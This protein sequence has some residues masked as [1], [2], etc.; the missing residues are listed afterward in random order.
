MDTVTRVYEAMFL[1]DSGKA[2]SEWESVNDAIK[3]ILERAGAEIISMRKWDERKLSY[4]VQKKARGT[5]ILV[6]FNADTQNIT[7]IERDVQLSEDVMRVLILKGDHITEDF[8]GKDTPVMA[9]EKAVEIAEADAA[10]RVKA[11]E[12]KA[13]AEEAPV[14][15][16][17]V[18]AEETQEVPEEKE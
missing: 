10:E 3:T 8:M 5:Y 15:E 18:V 9:A 16:E 17:A 12:E 7:G 2:A 14:V 1:V 13:A 4:D 6:Y 11:A